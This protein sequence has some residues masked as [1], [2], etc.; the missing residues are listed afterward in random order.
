[1]TK[2]PHRCHTQTFSRLLFTQAHLSY[3]ISLV[4]L[5][6]HIMNINVRKEKPREKK[7]INSAVRNQFLLEFCIL[8]L[9]DPLI[10]IPNEMKVYPQP[11]AL[12]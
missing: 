8:Y 3:K 6:M 2:T 12:G 9:V 5:V 10:I 7:T 1:M 4:Q 11:P